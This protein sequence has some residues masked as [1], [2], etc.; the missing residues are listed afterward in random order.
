MSHISN[1]RSTVR[2]CPLGRALAPAALPALPA[3]LASDSGRE[4]VAAEEEA[5]EFIEL[6]FVLG[7]PEATSGPPDVFPLRFIRKNLERD[8]V[9]AGL[10]SDGRFPGARWGR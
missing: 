7:F 3:P 4:L 6:G 1:A 2:L 8:L 5:D 10:G 9:C